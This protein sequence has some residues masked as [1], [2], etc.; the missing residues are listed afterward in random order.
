MTPE[1]DICITDNA[2]KVIAMETPVNLFRES[3]TPPAPASVELTKYLASGVSD[4]CI[5]PA[6][7]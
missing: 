5:K 1:H 2:E 4:F 6:D 7:A 3:G